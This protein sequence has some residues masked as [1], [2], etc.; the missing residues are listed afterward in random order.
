[1]KLKQ[2]SHFTVRSQTLSPDELTELFALEPDIAEVRGSR[3]SETPD[4]KP[5]P[6]THLWIV[7]CRD[8]KLSVDDQIS[9]ILKR[10]APAR[11]A[12]RRLV[13][14]H[15][16]ANATLTVARFFGGGEGEEQ[17][18]Y[19]SDDRRKDVLPF[20]WYL[21]DQALK[22]LS[23]VGAYLNVDEYDMQDGGG[24]TPSV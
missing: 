12:I 13:M 1:V 10:L 8:G 23:D 7:E 24:E 15:D 18:T 11:E 21:S 22:F 19:H 6:R 16:D 2:Y 3:I 9:A 20:G 14:E 4:R 5:V 17:V